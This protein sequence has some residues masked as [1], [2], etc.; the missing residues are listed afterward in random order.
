MGLTA[1]QQRFVDEYLVDL[2]GTQAAIRAGY[3]PKRAAETACELLRNPTVSQAIAERQN[4]Q[5]KKLEITH[6]MVLEGL[7]KQ[8]RM[9]EESV[10]PSM[11]SVRAWELIGRHIGMRFG[12]RLDVEVRL[13]E[14]LAMAVMEF[15]LEMPGEI[16]ERFRARLRQLG[17]DQAATLGLHVDPQ[18]K[19]H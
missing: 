12:D 16:Q 6:Q 5:T 19:G 2:N 8:A 13:N 4:R 18:A 7:L 10:R 9:G 3:S 15:F 1:R 17:Y 14:Q 11:P